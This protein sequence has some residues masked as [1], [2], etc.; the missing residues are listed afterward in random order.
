MPVTEV[1]PDVLWK[2]TFFPIFQKVSQNGALVKKYLRKLLIKI[3]K[4][5]RQKVIRWILGDILQKKCTQ[6]QKILPKWRNFAQ[7]GYTACEG[8]SFSVVSARMTT[9]RW[10]Q[11]LIKRKL[12][13]LSVILWKHIFKMQ[14]QFW[15]HTLNTQNS[16]L[17]PNIYISERKKKS[18]SQ[19][20]WPG[21][22]SKGLTIPWDLRPS[23][24][25]EEEE[26][27]FI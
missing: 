13:H 25:K 12:R 20:C 3:W 7:S 16:N 26:H 19:N 8:E 14:K 4:K 10:R 5:W 24:K 22:Y 21:V 15:K 18:S 17:T 11:F 27:L 2:K 1:R 9:S 6:S 23:I